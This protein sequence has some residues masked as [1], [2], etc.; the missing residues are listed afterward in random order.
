MGSVDSLTIIAP[1]QVK[2][3]VA[4]IK[5]PHFDRLTPRVSR[6]GRVRTLHHLTTHV[7]VIKKKMMIVIKINHNQY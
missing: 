6:L 2:G 3:T 7:K 5:S 1:A 4:V